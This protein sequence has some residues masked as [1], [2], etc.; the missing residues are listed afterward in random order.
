MVLANPRALYPLKF[1]PAPDFFYLTGIEEPEA[2]LVLDGRDKKAIVYSPKTA[3]F[4]FMTEGPGLLETPDAAKTF[5]IDKVVQ[6]SC[7]PFANSHAAA[8]STYR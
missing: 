4:R 7:S 8:R 1:R 2:L 3:G 5:G 6:H